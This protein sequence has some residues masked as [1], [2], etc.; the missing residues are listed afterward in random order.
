MHIYV[1]KLNASH[2]NKPDNLTQ[3]LQVE[4]IYPCSTS[5]VSAWTASWLRSDHA[6]ATMR[7]LATLGLSTFA[8]PAT[9]TLA[10]SSAHACPP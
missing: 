8:V 3:T 4:E 5:M 7:A 6:H 9:C 10:A 2:V 1:H